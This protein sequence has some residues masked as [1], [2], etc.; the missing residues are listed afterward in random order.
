M[1]CGHPSIGVDN[2]SVWVSIG[3]KTSIRL[4]PRLRI[5]SPKPTKQGVGLGGFGLFGFVGLTGG[6]NRFLVD[7]QNYFELIFSTKKIII[8]NRLTIE[9]VI[10][11]KMASHQK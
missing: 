7:P 1:F 10:I 5:L 4:G 8:Q 3:L 6:F 9:H 2:R 11:L